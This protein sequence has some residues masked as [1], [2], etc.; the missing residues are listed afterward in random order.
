MKRLLVVYHS[1]S[2]TTA[3]LARAVCTGARREEE[4]ETVVYP[5]LEADTTALLAA[6]AVLFGTPENLGYISGGLKNFFDI[7]NALIE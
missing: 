7:F 4:V 5:A 1:Q 3:A 6:D 2:G